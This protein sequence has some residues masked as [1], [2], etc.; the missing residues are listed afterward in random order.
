MTE[1]KNIILWLYTCCFMVFAMAIIGAITRLTESGLSMVEW[2][3]LIGA[4]PP[5]NEQEWGRVYDLYKQSPEF[6]HKHNWMTLADFKQIFFWEWFHRLWGRMIGLVYA[7]PLLWFWL[8]KEIPQGYGK[9]LAGI[10][11]LGG[12]Q[13]LMGWYMVMSGLSDR[14]EVSHYRLAAHLFLALLVFS[15]LWWVALDLMPPKHSNDN[16][17]RSVSVRFKRLGWG[18]L[19]ML[20]IT[21]IWGA[22]VAG[23][24]AGMI[25]NSFPLMG[26]SFLPPESFSGAHSIFEQHAWV[27]FAHRWLA[28]TTGGLL[29][30]YAFRLD[31]RPLMFMVC[32]QIGLGISTLLSQIMLPI[33]VAHQGG[34]II[35]L[36]LT[37]RAQNRLARKQSETTIKST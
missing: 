20:G 30:F 18:L 13:G 10:L 36:A 7:L 22:F 25:Y 4:L 9:K 32:L 37:L 26:G 15:A 19:I 23:L 12:L 17:R 24:D 28:V 33:A 6:T 31:D 5:L 35:L 1:N 3:P 27:Q 11:C 8:R 21:V 2:R 16:M 14:P 29:L 34:A